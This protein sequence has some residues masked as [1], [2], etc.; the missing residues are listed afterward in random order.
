MVQYKWLIVALICL[1]ILI[2]AWL[3]AS[4]RVLQ[5]RLSQLLWL[6]DRK[7]RP[8]TKSS[9]EVSHQG[10][11]TDMHVHVQKIERTLVKYSVFNC[12]KQP[13]PFLSWFHVHQ[14]LHT[15]ARKCN[16]RKKHVGTASC[17]VYANIYIIMLSCYCIY[18]WFRMSM[19]NDRQVLIIELNCTGT[20]KE[21]VGI[22]AALLVDIICNSG[23]RF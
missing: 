8:A 11:I 1:I 3:P 6:Q 16:T 10:V 12:I 21:T 19:C 2:Q 14:V 4:A 7:A 22:E 9:S 18:V 17:N 13:T 15:C 23:A 5:S 20:W